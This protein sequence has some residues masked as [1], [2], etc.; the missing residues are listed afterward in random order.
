MKNS[1]FFF[2]SVLV[3]VFLGAGLTAGAQK[4]PNL[5]Q[6][7]V[8]APAN[9]KIDG[10]TD[11]WD[12]QFQAFNNATEIF[13]TISNNTENLYLTIRATEVAVIQKIVA[14]GVSFTLKSTDKKSTVTPVNIIYPLVQFQFS[15]VNY[16]LK[17]TEPITDQALNALNK[18]LTDHQK[19]ITIT[20]VKE[21]PDTAVSV[22]NEQG[23]KTAALVDNKKAYTVEM[24]IPLKYL[25]QE[26]NGAG[27]FGY[28]LQLN[29]LSTQNVKVVGGINPNA[30][31]S[32]VPLD[33]SAPNF[34]FAPT[35]CKGEYTLAKK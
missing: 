10:K 3:S 15:Q 19:D 24:A 13:Y 33:H 32:D 23:I 31:P 9:I 2:K 8:Y 26:I 6:Q 28:I 7:S 20:G 35:Y 11:E 18:Q 16:I 25:Q 4:L 21:F 17:K 14:G 27:M 5:Q 30:D 12:S 1:T 29:G 34:E 22:Y